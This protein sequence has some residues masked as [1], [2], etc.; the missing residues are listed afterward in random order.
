MTRVEFMNELEKLLCDISYEERQDA[1][2]YYHDYFSDAGMENEA[3]VIRELGSPQRVAMQIK[4]S[5]NQTE[6]P[7][8]G[9][10]GNSGGNRATNINRKNN[11]TLKLILIVLLLFCGWPVIL[12]VL[13]IVFGLILSVVGLLFGVG[14]SGVAVL[15]S[16]IAVFVVGIMLLISSPALAMLLFGIGILLGVVGLLVTVLICKIV[17]V[18]VPPLC[19]G[20]VLLCK[21]PFTSKVVA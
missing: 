2:N 10:V 21:K 1:L 20:F 18:F 4:E 5:L 12:A 15:F 14:I 6:E 3:A 7:A 11:K 8:S 13:G 17:Q 16:G 9:N 19:R